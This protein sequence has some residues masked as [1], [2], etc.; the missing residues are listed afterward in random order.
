[1][2]LQALLQRLRRPA[3]PPERLVREYGRDA[4]LVWAN[5]LIAPLLARL[6]LRVG[7][8]SEEQ[9]AARMEADATAMRRRGYLVAKVETF[10]LPVVG[11][12]PGDAASW[13]RVT[14]E[15]STT[16]ERS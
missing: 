3:T 7:L 16:P 9:L 15:R 10:S 4:L 5:V 8:R 2:Q 6:G 13:Y 11:A 1:M 12:A 14:Y